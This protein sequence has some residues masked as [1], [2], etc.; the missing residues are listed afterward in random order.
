MKLILEK[1]LQSNKNNDLFQKLKA[2]QGRLNFLP[3]FSKEQHVMFK[4]VLKR[5]G[6]YSDVFSIT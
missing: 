1:L 3:K 4:K 2:L 6:G 5:A